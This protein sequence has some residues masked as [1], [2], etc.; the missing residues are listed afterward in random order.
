ML[1]EAKLLRWIIQHLKLE[2]GASILFFATSLLSTLGNC[3]SIFW[4]QTIFAGDMTGEGPH[5]DQQQF[6]RAEPIHV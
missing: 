6:G 5:H 2:I 4:L 3:Q 1:K